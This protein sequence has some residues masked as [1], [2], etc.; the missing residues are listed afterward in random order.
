MNP[1]EAMNKLS[2]LP[3]QALYNLAI[4]K[5]VAEEDIN[6]MDKTDIIKKLLL[7]GISEDEINAA[8]DDYIYGMRVTF[9][10][11]GISRDLREEDFS[12]LLELSGTE[13][14]W[15]EVDGFR[16]LQYISVKRHTDRLEILYSY[17]KDEIVKLK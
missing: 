16:N 5:N 8:V 13:E 11:W 2:T 14:P 1:D 3:W 9:T 15:I 10:L 4:E 17:S 12:L 6:G 7:T